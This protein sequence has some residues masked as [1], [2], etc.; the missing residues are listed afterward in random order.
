MEPLISQ[1]L[2]AEVEKVGIKRSRI[3]YKFTEKGEK[4]LEYIELALN[5]VSLKE[6]IQI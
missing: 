3:R 6:E 4:F 2:L 1:G 5:S